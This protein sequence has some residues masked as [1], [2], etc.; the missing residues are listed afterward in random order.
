MEA[1]RLPIKMN[2]RQRAPILGVVGAPMHFTGPKLSLAVCP[3][4]LSACSA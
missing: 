3:R 4:S 2:G 1:E